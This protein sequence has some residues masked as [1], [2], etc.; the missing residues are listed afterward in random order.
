MLVVLFFATFLIKLYKGELRKDIRKLL[1]LSI[2][3]VP[4]IL[5]KLFCYSEGINSFNWHSGNIQIFHNTILSNFLPRLSDLGNYKLI[6]YFLLLNE[7]FLIALTLFLL[8]SWITKNKD[9]S[10]YLHPTLLQD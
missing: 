1:L 3:F 10:W 9:L 6:G 5:W 8:S 4:I 2:S 7:K